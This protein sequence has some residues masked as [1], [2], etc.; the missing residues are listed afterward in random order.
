MRASFKV[1][2]CFAGLTLLLAG[3]GGDGG[4]GGLSNPDPGNNDVNVVV[5][6]GDSIT[7]GS[8]CACAPYPARLAALIG[9]TVA[10]CGISGS[11]ATLSVGRTQSAIDKYHPGFMVILYGINDLIMGEGIDSVI[12]ALDAMIETCKK[13]NVVPVIMTYPKPITGHVIFSGRTLRL[14]AQIRS[15]ADTKGIRCV[16]LETEFAD[17]A[18]WYERD[19]LHPNNAGTDAIALA[20]ADLF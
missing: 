18:D 14:N 1:M 19:G 13:N 20:V 12:G 16:D 7:K 6:F 8:E 5:C 17:N 10:N 15:M 9:K 11:R 2:A 3:C 4:S